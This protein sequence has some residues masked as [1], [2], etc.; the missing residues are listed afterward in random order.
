MNASRD[1][2]YYSTLYDGQ[3]VDVWV[4]VCVRVEGKYD[5]VLVGTS[6]VRV[7]RRTLPVPVCAHSIR[8]CFIYVLETEG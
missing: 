6:A 3:V 2:M 1:H 5:E 8:G 4:F 7:F